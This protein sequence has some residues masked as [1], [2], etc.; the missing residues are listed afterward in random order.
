MGLLATAVS[1][2]AVGVDDAALVGDV[3]CS[4]P[5]RTG[6]NI[7]IFS[8]LVSF[9]FGVLY[10]MKVLDEE[11]IRQ[12]MGYIRRRYDDMTLI[13]IEKKIVREPRMGFSRQ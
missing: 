3:D 5:D 13:D 4:L 10:N 12:C 7:I 11:M 1:V 8:F 6:C 9:F 2:V